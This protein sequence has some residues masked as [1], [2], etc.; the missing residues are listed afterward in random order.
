MG[1]MET[2][3]WSMAKCAKK[4]KIEHHLVCFSASVFGASGGGVVA[5]PTSQV[6]VRSR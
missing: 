1:D 5:V 4:K 2:S 6:E 3:F